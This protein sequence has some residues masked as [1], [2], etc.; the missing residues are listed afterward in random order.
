MPSDAFDAKES[1]EEAHSSTLCM[2][3]PGESHALI[4][5]GVSWADSAW[6]IVA[7]IMHPLLLASLCTQSYAQ[8]SILGLISGILIPISSLCSPMFRILHRKVSPLLHAFICAFEVSNLVQ[9]LLAKGKTGFYAESVV[10]RSTNASVFKLLIF[11]CSVGILSSA[12]LALKGFLNPKAEITGNASSSLGKFKEILPPIINVVYFIAFVIFI[13]FTAASI[14]GLVYIC[15]FIT[16]LVV[17]IISKMGVGFGTQADSLQRLVYLNRLMLGFTFFSQALISTH[18]ISITLTR[19]NLWQSDSHKFIFGLMS[20]EIKSYNLTNSVLFALLCTISMLNAIFFHFIRIS[21]SNLPQ[22]SRTFSNFS[23][24]DEQSSEASDESA[25]NYSQAPSSVP[26]SFRL[27]IGKELKLILKILFHSIIYSS[28][29]LLPLCFCLGLFC[30]CFFFRGLFSWI[31]LLIFLFSIGNGFIS[32]WRIIPFLL[33]I[34]SANIFVFYVYK[35][36][37]GCQIQNRMCAIMISSNNFSNAQEFG[38]FALLMTILLISFCSACCRLSVVKIAY[39][40]DPSRSLNSPTFLRILK[41]S[42][43]NSFFLLLQRIPAKISSYQDASSRNILHFLVIHD[44][45]LMLIG[46][47]I[48]IPAESWKSL[49]YERDAFGQTCFDYAL[50]GRYSMVFILRACGFQCDSKLSLPSRLSFR[51]K[52]SKS[53]FIIISFILYQSRNLSLIPVYLTSLSNLGIMHLGMLALFLTIFSRTKVTTKW[54]SVLWFYC[55]LVYFVFYGFE[56]F[57]STDFENEKLWM[58]IF[59]SQTFN[60]SRSLWYLAFTSAI[61]SVQYYLIAIS[62]ALESSCLNLQNLVFEGRLDLS[63]GIHISDDFA[64]SDESESIEA[65]SSNLGTVLIRGYWELFRNPWMLCVLY[66]TYALILFFQDIKLLNF[67]YLII[68]SLF[69]LFQ[70]L[71]KKSSKL[72]LKPIFLIALFYSSAVLLLSYASLDESV[73]SFFKRILSFGNIVLSSEIGL[74]MHPLSSDPINLL[75]VPAILFFVTVF[76]NQSIY[77][78]SWNVFKSFPDNTLSSLER[79]T[80]EHSREN[81]PR[82]VWETL[83]CRLHDVFILIITIFT[84]TL[85]YLDPNLPNFLLFVSSIIL[86]ALNFVKSTLISFLVFPW[87]IIVLKYIANFQSF[88][89]FVSKDINTLLGTSSVCYNRLSHFGCS[90]YYFLLTSFTLITLI[91]KR[92]VHQ[93]FQDLH[94]DNLSPEV[95]SSHQ[96]LALSPDSFVRFSS[97][98]ARSDKSSISSRSTFLCPLIKLL[99]IIF[100]FI[101]KNIRSITLYLLIFSALVQFDVFALIIVLVLGFPV[102]NFSSK[103]DTFLMISFTIPSLVLVREVLLFISNQSVMP[104]FVYDF[105]FKNMDKRLLEFL[106]AS[107]IKPGSVFL[108]FL[109]FLLWNLFYKSRNQVRF[110]MFNQSLG[111]RDLL[112]ELSPINLVFL[113]LTPI[114]LQIILTIAFSMVLHSLSFIGAVHV[115][116]LSVIS[117]LTYPKDMLIL[118]R[119]IIYIFCCLCGI[120]WVPFWN[121]STGFWG[122]NLGLYHIYSQL[123]IFL[124]IDLSIQLL[125]CSFYN[126]LIFLNTVMDSNVSFKFLRSFENFHMTLHDSHQVQKMHIKD[127]QCL[128]KILSVDILKGANLSPIRDEELWPM[129][130]NSLQRFFSSS[131]KIHDLLYPALG[132]IYDSK[133]DDYIISDAN[134]SAQEILKQFSKDEENFP[135]GV[136]VKAVFPKHDHEKLDRLLAACASLENPGSHAFISKLENV[137]QEDYESDINVSGLGIWDLAGSSSM[138][139]VLILEPIYWNK[140]ENQVSMEKF[141][142]ELNRFIFPAVVLNHEAKI[143]A[144]NES[145]KQQTDQICVVNL[146]SFLSMFLLSETDSQRE[147]LEK[148]LNLAQSSEAPQKISISISLQNGLKL[149]IT[150]CPWCRSLTAEKSFVVAFI[151]PVGFMTNLKFYFRF[152]YSGI[153]KFLYENCD[154]VIF[155]YSE[156]TKIAMNAKVKYWKTLYDLDPKHLDFWSL[157]LHFIQS[158]SLIII[159]AYFLFILIQA[160]DLLNIIPVFCLLAYGLIGYPRAGKGFWIFIACFSIFNITTRFISQ[161]GLIC[162]SFSGPTLWPL[163]AS[164]CIEDPF[165]AYYLTGL[166]Q[167]KNLILE[168][169]LHFGSVLMIRWRKHLMRR[170]GVWN[171]SIEQH[172]LSDFQIRK[173]RFKANN[174]SW[175]FLVPKFVQDFFW[176]ITPVDSRGRNDSRL[177]PGKSFY[178]LYA[179]IQVFSIFYAFLLWPYMTRT[180]TSGADSISSSYFSGDM[181]IFVISLVFLV[182]LDRVIFIYKSNVW[183]LI[184][185]YVFLVYIHYLVFFRWPVKSRFSLSTNPFLMLFYFVQVTYF[186][187][188]A[189]QIRYGFPSFDRFY[190]SISSKANWNRRLVYMIYQIIPLLFEINVVLDWMLIPTSLDLFS[191][192]Y[193]E[194][195]Y[196]NFYL[197]KVG[198]VAQRDRFRGEIRGFVE[199]FFAGFLLFLGLVLLLFGPLVLFSSVNPGAEVAQVL[200]ASI[201]L[202]VG[203]STGSYRLLT[204]SSMLN[205]SVISSSE[206]TKFSELGYIMNEP[207]KGIQRITMAASSNSVW[208]ISPSS[209]NFLIS[210]LKDPSQ[211]I[212]LQFLYS[213]G[214]NGPGTGRIA[215]SKST[216]QLTNFQAATLGNLLN[217]SE[218]TETFILRGLFPTFLRIS[219]HDTPSVIDSVSFFLMSFF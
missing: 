150:L 164:A 1:L 48:L 141:D 162:I 134:E 97:D 92:V 3:S 202:V 91:L 145:L 176:S 28:R 96:L 118:Y 178:D 112:D 104:D 156:D 88:Q 77:F 200:S 211:K 163:D 107:N 123:L 45:S 143:V 174:E 131:L 190:H 15:I 154:P 194:Q 47:L 208:D 90:F 33:P 50:E 136:E 95:S 139:S 27:Y 170:K 81:L 212:T 191:T 6:L 198:L 171:V 166:H 72:N 63:T 4:D 153:R 168:M 101:S 169:L 60:F 167:S 115:I 17:W 46:F 102:F 10:I 219:V 8:E 55:S 207:L 32:I 49:L 149:S 98:V 23:S 152:L 192:L 94:V 31:L 185:H 183:K 188:S 79:K 133:K 41:S 83:L 189:I 196:Y 215:S 64:L 54:W 130:R 87:I 181:V 106:G 119:K 105:F 124:F 213:F 108:Q 160:P 44:Q 140:E 67:G 35:L 85:V 218:P 175:S 147:R 216:K 34:I 78:K 142:M 5:F 114:S 193:L 201:S 155:D 205:S 57:T 172:P 184:L 7:L 69:Y 39:T 80:T 74:P 111:L 38:S 151:Y 148:A 58:R 204:I 9:I 89:G 128:E 132:L 19:S 11:F 103:R 197:I 195:A 146:E 210:S 24:F 53:F 22:H 137:P 56:M 52:A 86:I 144:Y 36:V 2:S 157:L 116:L 159:C 120:A 109:A 122:P 165:S 203:T 173:N 209:Q 42:D 117:L 121:L 62:D 43:C 127:L 37:D 110:L 25:S 161:L 199:K 70:G 187:V 68:L 14:F 138:S 135:I 61:L 214:M 126:D 206:Y 59:S 93:D 158:N 21:R 177:K 113:Y 29:A 84:G 180:G 16:F 40:S 51:F 217:S 71:R 65:L 75:R 30:Y 129:S 182:L 179:G 66:L 13:S 26:N 186:Y 18:Y 76:T 125:N 82:L 99:N 20:S 12:I 100:W 73:F